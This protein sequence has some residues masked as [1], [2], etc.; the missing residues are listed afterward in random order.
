MNILITG[1][2]GMLGRALQDEFSNH[3]LSYVALDKSSCDITNPEALSAS[4]EKYSP[5]HLINCAAYTAVDKAEEETDLAYAINATGVANV[6]KAC[7]ASNISL[8]HIST[9]YVFDGTT[10]EP[11]PE[12]HPTN[13]FLYTVPANW[14][15]NVCCY[16][17]V[18]MARS[19]EHSGCMDHMESTLSQPCFR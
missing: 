9:D 6:A 4:L 14:K 19:F 15:E 13:L 1:G 7:H 18:L 16:N 12:T 2:Q 17:T 8:V 10:K 3:N 5:T 11:Y